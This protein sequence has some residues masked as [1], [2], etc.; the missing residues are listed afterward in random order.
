V[1]GATVKLCFTGTIAAPRRRIGGTV[2]VS[3]RADRTTA[4]GQEAVI[5]PVALFPA[6]L[7]LACRDGRGQ[8]NEARSGY[9]RCSCL[10]DPKR[11][12]TTGLLLLFSCGSIASSFSPPE[13]G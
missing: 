9:V 5:A 6:R 7:A 12:V 8:K 3:R 10:G 13:S 4:G 11:L 1:L 2:C